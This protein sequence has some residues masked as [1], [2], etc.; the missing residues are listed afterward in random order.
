VNKRIICNNAN[1]MAIKSFE[2]KCNLEDSKS[3]HNCI[4]KQKIETKDWAI[5]KE[6]WKRR[7]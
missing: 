6:L 4:G 5:E 3:F 2:Q 7:S 1:R